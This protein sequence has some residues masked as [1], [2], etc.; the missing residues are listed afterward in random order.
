MSVTGVSGMLLILPLRPLGLCYQ[1]WPM[2]EWLSAAVCHQL[3]Q[4]PAD[5]ESLHWGIL[6]AVAKRRQATDGVLLTVK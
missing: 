4:A 6:K 3:P 5:G 2:T 1:P